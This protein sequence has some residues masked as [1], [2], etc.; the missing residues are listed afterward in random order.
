M[1]Q[2][3][4]TLESLIAIAPLVGNQQN[5]DSF[6]LGALLAKLL[7]D[8]LRDLD[9]AVVD[10]NDIAR[11]LAAEKHALPLTEAASQT[12]RDTLNLRA[13]VQGRYVL[14]EEGK[15]V[16]FSLVVDAPDI[17]RIPLEASAPI[18]GFG[19]FVERVVLAL[20][21]QMQV[22]ID[23]DLRQQVAEI[24]KPAFEAL[25]QMARAQSAWARGQHDMALASV[26]S[27]LSIEPDYEDAAALEVAVARAAG[28][29]NTVR[30]AFRRWSS[31]AGKQQRSSDSA[32]RLLALGHWLAD[33]GEWDEARRA[34]DDARSIYQREGDE[35]GQA[36]AINDLGNLELLRGSFQNA[37]Q[38]YR[39]NLRVFETQSELSPDVSSTLYNL[40][41]AH[42]NLGQQEEA[43]RAIE[44]AL[45]IARR[46]NS[47][48][49]EARCLAQRGALFDEMGRWSRADS[50]YTQAARLLDVLGD[51]RSLAVVKTHQAILA[52]QQGAYDRAE[53]LLL[54]AVELL[55]HQNAPHEQA[56]VWL[57]LSDLYLAMGLY[58]QAW[59]FAERSH[60]ALTRLKSGWLERAKELLDTLESIPEESEPEPEQD[61]E[62]S[63]PD[64]RTSA[65]T[66]SQTNLFGSQP[67]SEKPPRFLGGPYSSSSD[68]PGNSTPD[69]D[70]PG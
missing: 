61:Q 22:E 3:A 37:I 65:N 43:E 4:P 47:T 10:Y 64:P 33:R 2:P 34:Y 7:A 60:T 8:H 26:T 5:D 67:D 56:I 14:D 54:E 53:T 12:V 17:A 63:P 9:F 19:R 66:F 49:L 6:W 57:N 41:V 25:R 50:D 23:D 27:A 31:I 45:T 68:L 44:H 21:A 42:T 39:R 35:V 48:H 69:P 18:P 55:D 46:L 59:E 11:H 51:E 62:P 24:R 20:L 70:G 1:E 32:E 52:R 13:L 16:G 30:D 38:A 29:T 36:R 40:S 58:E 15:M 28:D